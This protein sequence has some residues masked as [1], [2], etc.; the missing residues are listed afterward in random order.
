MSVAFVDLKKQYHDLQKELE[1]AFHNVLEKGQFIDGVEV[2]L[3]EKE[4]AAFIDSKYCITVNSGTD[5]LILGVRALNIPAGSEVIVPGNTF[6]ATALAAS[7]NNL[8][9]VFVDM[10]DDYGMNLEDLKN[11]INDRTK[12]VMVVHLYGQPDKVDEIQNI[13]NASGK[14]IYLIEDS[15][16]TH[17]AE[18]NG[19]KT[20]TFGIFSAFSF[21]PGKNL[22]AYGDGGAIITQD[23]K[24]ADRY[25]LLKEYGSRQK[26]FHETFGINSR[27][28]TI[29]AAILRVKLKHLS[30]WNK[31]RQEMAHYYT[32]KLAELAPQLTTPTHFKNRESIYHVYVVRT[33]KRDALQKFLLTKGITTLIHYPLP[34]HLQKAYEFLNYKKGDLPNIEQAADEILSLPMYPELT[35]E[36]ADA[37]VA[38]I[39]EFYTLHG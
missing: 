18:L 31:Q 22:G 32:Q 20:G 6:F 27:L 4:F 13:I 28:D 8:K 33:K 15:A 7:E 14:K 29:Q 21:Y 3:F 17:G 10:D 30:N 2:N 24:L 34:L 5:A 37:V 35:K 38:A 26:Y 39:K 12:A 11:K 16:Q 23:A 1:V 9:P 25:K 36:S 19:K